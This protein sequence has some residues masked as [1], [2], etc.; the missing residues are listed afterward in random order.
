MNLILNMHD[1]VGLGALLLR[2][3]L[4]HRDPDFQREWGDGEVFLRCQ[5]CGLRSYGVQTGP[6]RLTT[7]TSG[8]PGH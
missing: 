2:H 5:R 1:A 3:D 6:V 7:R 4:L 8:H